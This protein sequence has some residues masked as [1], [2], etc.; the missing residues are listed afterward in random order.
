VEGVLQF[1]SA[2][3]DFYRSGVITNPDQG[4]V[5]VEH[6]WSHHAA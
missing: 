2:D 5:F 6:H 1:E 4:I 3:G